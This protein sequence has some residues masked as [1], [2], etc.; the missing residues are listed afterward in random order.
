MT[1]KQYQRYSPEFKI[2]ALKRAN[3]DGVTDKAVF[4]D[5]QHGSR[6]FSSVGNKNPVP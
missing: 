2:H 6:A 3:E 1:K 4:A 5:Q